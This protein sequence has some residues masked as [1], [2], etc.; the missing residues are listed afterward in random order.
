MQVNALTTTTTN[1][2]IYRK[3]K[4][5]NNMSLPFWILQ[6]IKQHFKILQT[7]FSELS[8]QLAKALSSLIQT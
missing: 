6:S 2:R 4:A 3:W 5:V 7:L 1:E 8:E